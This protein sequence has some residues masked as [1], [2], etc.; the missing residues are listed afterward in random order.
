VLHAWPPGQS[1]ATLQPQVPPGSHAEPA[2]LLAQFAHAPPLV[3]QALAAVPPTHVVPLQQ[4]PLHGVSF[5]TPHAV[6]H[7]CVWVL[8]ALPAGQSVAEPQPQVSVPGSQT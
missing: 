4:P 7:V 1:V 6:E 2:E 5:A 3:P 8:H